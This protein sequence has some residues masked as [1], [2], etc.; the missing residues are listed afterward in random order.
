MT[1]LISIMIMSTISI[2]SLVVGFLAIQEIRSSRAVLLSEPAINA[3]ESGGEYGTWVI[4][5][6]VGAIATCPAVTQSSLG[7]NAKVDICKS[8]SSAVIALKANIPY[9]L[10]LY[11]PNDVNGNLCMN[12]VYTPSCS[13]AAV[14]TSFSTVHKA[15]L[16][17]ILV[18]IETLSGQSFAGST[19]AV[20]PGGNNSI[21]IPDPIPSATDE[22]MKVTLTSVSD[23][24]VEINAL[25]LG[26]SDFPTV[27][28]SGCTSKSTIA[29]CAGTEETFKRRI[30]ITIPQ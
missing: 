24:E 30:N 19:M 25:P 14:Y 5:R 22:R 18:A 11:D 6:G 27:N 8:Y 28:S 12:A 23:S 1:L 16:N 13:G 29:N 4:K 15:G 3:A 2:I 21:S 20:P 10:Y 17:N 26:L 7:N 9:V